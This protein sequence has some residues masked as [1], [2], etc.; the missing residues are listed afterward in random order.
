MREILFR[1]KNIDTGEWWHGDLFHT[2]KRVFIRRPIPPAETY[3]EHDEVI[4]ETV[5]QYTGLTDKNGKKIFEGDIIKSCEY[6]DIY[7][8]K[9]CADANYPAFDVVPEINV[10]CN[11]LSHLHIVEGIEVVGNKWDN[12]ELLK[13]GGEE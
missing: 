13:G 10:E 12:P 3:Y 1:G 2:I 9:Y 4:P 6:D 8:V 11:G 5:G 7:F